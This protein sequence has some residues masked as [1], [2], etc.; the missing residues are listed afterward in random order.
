MCRR[1]FVKL[2]DLMKDVMR[3]A[4]GVRAVKFPE[5]LMM[6][7]CLSNPICSTWLTFS[8]STLAI[9]VERLS[10]SSFLVAQ[11]THCWNGS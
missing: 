2:C 9:S 10:T 6:P 4:S 1:S 7:Q 3:P 11:P 5:V 8:L